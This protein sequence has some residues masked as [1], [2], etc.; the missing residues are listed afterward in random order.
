MTLEKH[1]ALQRIEQVSERIGRSKSWIWD[2]VKRGDFP[3]PVRLS[4]RCTRWDSLAVDQWIEAQ[5]SGM[6]AI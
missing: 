5:L 2:A 4:T 1:R 3:S 6:E